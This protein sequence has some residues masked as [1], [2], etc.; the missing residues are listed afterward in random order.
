MVLCSCTDMVLSVLDVLTLVLQ[1]DG[2]IVL[3]NC[4]DIVLC[5]PVSLTI[6]LQEKEKLTEGRNI[7][8]TGPNNYK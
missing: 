7:S 3:C 4:T 1:D 6:V 2:Y 5:N 8:Q